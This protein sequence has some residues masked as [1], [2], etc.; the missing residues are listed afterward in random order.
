MEQIVI[1]ANFQELVLITVLKFDSGI[2][3]K[4]SS[5]IIIRFRVELGWVANMKNSQHFLRFK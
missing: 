3:I 5:T 1:K 2:D 4:V